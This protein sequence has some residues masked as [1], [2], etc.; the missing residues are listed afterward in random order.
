[1]P[2]SLKLPFRRSSRVTS[3][4]LPAAPVASIFCKTSLLPPAVFLI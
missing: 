2:S 4:F 3:S 1:M